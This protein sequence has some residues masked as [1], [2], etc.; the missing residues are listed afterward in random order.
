VKLIIDLA[1]TV[2]AIKFYTIAYLSGDPSTK[3]KRECKMSSCAAHC[4]QPKYIYN[5][6][7]D[8]L[9]F[10]VVR[11]TCLTAH[12]LYFWRVTLMF[13]AVLLQVDITWSK[14]TWQCCPLT[15]L[16]IFYRDTWWFIN[17]KSISKGSM[18][19]TS[20]L[21]NMELPEHLPSFDPGC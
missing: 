17:N 15:Y 14:T 21:L 18:L 1:L 10:S 19:I 4:C 11:M 16:F 9:F 12:M 2:S 5:V 3:L 8:F 6:A 7:S 20:R 13:C